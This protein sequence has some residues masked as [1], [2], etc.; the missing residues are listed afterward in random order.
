MNDYYWS[1][2]GHPRGLGRCGCTSQLRLGLLLCVVAIALLDS[3]C[4]ALHPEGVH[5]RAVGGCNTDGHACM[6]PSL[7][8]SV[9]RFGEVRVVQNGASWAQCLAGC[10][11]ICARV[12]RR[13]PVW[14][15]P[16][17]AARPVYGAVVTASRWIFW[18]LGL[19][20]CESMQVLTTIG[21]TCS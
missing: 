2:C 5:G 17:H 16:V 10:N 6:L 11:A 4:A 21:S 7:G 14:W 8:L 18:G 9:V 12:L 3:V 20:D 13:D 1:G 19:W 15:R